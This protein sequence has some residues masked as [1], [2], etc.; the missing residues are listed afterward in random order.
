MRVTIID[1]GQGDA[2]LVQ[3]PSGHALL[4]DAGGTARPADIGTRIVTPAIW[5]LGARRLDWLAV[6]HAD[7]DHI[8]G[9]LAVVADL[10]PREIW[11]AV[12]V[13]ASAERL[14]LWNEARAHDIVWRQVVAGHHLDVGGVAI[15]A[16]HPP[17]P[18][19]ERQ[20]VRNDDSMVLG[21]RFGEVEILLAGDAGAEFES[22][23][24][25]GRSPAPLRVLKVAHHGS[26]TS[27]SEPF[28]RAVRPHLALISAGRGNPFGHPS[29]DVLSRLGELDAMVF[30]TDLDGAI[31]IETDGR[32]VDVRTEAGRA[33]KLSVDGR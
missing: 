23:A 14:A 24:V 2:A 27:S 13:P 5:A 17:A 31:R 3:T 22:R 21:V 7:I 15:D 1:V 18:D 6:T 30:R 20:R 9:A 28:L 8:G 4:V 33:W 10:N 19:W 32:R 11:E 26:R 16:L 29:P 25:T 12:P